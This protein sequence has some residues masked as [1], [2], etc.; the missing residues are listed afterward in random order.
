MNLSNEF[1]D[2]SITE[3]ASFLKKH[4]IDSKTVSRIR[5]VAEEILLHYRDKF[6]SETEASFVCAKKPGHLNITF[7]VRCERNEPSVNITD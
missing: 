1:I 6:G 2:R 3:S 4:D 5:I 7:K